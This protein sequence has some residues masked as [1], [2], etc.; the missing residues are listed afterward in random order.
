LILAL[1]ILVVLVLVNFASISSQSYEFRWWDT[2]WHY[3]VGLEVNSTGYNRTNWTIEYDINFTYLL[4]NMSVYGAL[5]E[6]STRVVEYNTTGSILWEVPSQFDRADNYNESS[7]AAGT[8]VFMMNGTTAADQKR[9]FFVYFDTTEH[10]SKNKPSYTT[11]LF[12][13]YTGNVSEFNINN[14]YFRWWVDTERGEN[15]SG[16]YYVQD[17]AYENDILK[18][19]PAD[20][21]TVEYSE[22]SNAT[23]KFGFDFRNNATFKYAGPSRIV[24]EQ[25]GYETL[26]DQPDNKTNEGYMIKRYTFY[27]YSDWMK[28][29]QIFVNNAS[30]NITRN[31]TAAGALAI[32]VNYSFSIPGVGNEFYPNMSS[33]D[34]PGSYGW[35]AEEGYTWWAGIINLYENGTSNFFATEHSDTGRI[36]VQLNETNISAGSTIRHV[37]VVQ[38]NTNGTMA[39]DRFRNFVNQSIMQLNVTAYTSEAWTVIVDGK[40]YMNSTNEANV[41]NRNET[42]IIRANVTDLY[43]LSDKVNASLD[44]GGAGELNLTLYD[45]GTHGDTQANDNIYANTYNIADSDAIGAWN[46][47]FRVY[48]QSDH[49]LSISWSAFNVTNVYNV[50]VNITNPTGFTDRIVNT[51]VYVSNYRRDLWI[52]NA[53]L[54]CT[55]ESTQIPQ[56]NISDNGDGTY[57]VWFKAPSY[58]GLF[59]LNCNAT[60]NNNTGSGTGEFSCNTYTTNMSIS[61]S[62]DNF[63]AGNVTSYSNQTFNITVF[64]ENTANGTAYDMNITLNFPTTNITANTTFASCGDVLITKNCTRTFQI[65]M[66]NATPQGNYSVNISATW[67]NWV[68]FPPGQNSTLLNVTILANP[69]L[70]VSKNYILGIIAPGK[71]P[72]NIDNFTVS[73]LGNEPLQNVTF[74]LQGFS[75]NF[76]FQFVPVNFSFI[77][78][79]VAENVEIMVNSTD[80]TSPGEY[81]GTINVTSANNGFKTINI[82]VAVSG[83]NMTIESDKYNFTAENVTWYQNQSFPILVNTTNI[84][85]SSAYNVTIRLNFSSTNITTN[86]TSRYCGNVPKSGVCNASFLIIILSQ[87]H[88][89]NYTANVSVEWENPEGSTSVNVTTI[90]ITVLSHINLSIPQDSFST[91]VSHGTEKEIGV[92]I[93]NS[94]GNDPVENI[95]FSVYNFSSNFAFEFVPPNI[96]SLGGEYPQGAK[97]NVTVAFG[98][99]PGVYTGKLNVTTSNDGYKEINLT[100]EVPLSRTWTINTTYCEKAESPEEGVACDVLINNTGNAVINYS[101]TPVTN[102]TPSGMFNFTWTNET[103]FTLAS[104]Q[105]HAFSVLYNITNQTIKFYYANYTVNAVQSGSNPDYVILQIVLSPYIKPLISVLVA[106]NQTEQI[107]SVWIYANVTDQGGAGIGYNATESNVTV[108]VLRPDGSNSTIFMTFYGGIPTGG[109]SFWRV[110]YPDNPYAP[111][112]G[113]WG[114]TTSK[115]YYNVSVYAIDNMGKNNTDNTSYFQIYSKLLVG[116]NAS[117]YVYLG[118]FF[119]EININTHDVEGTIL[120][121]TNVNLTLADPNGKN[122]TSYIWMG[123]TFVTDSNGDASGFYFIPQNA[124]LGNYTFTAN[125]THYLAGVNKTVYNTTS[126]TFEVEQSSELA[127]EVE[128]PEYAYISSN[129]PVLV[130]VL[131]NGIPAEPDAINLTIFYRLP[132]AYCPSGEML[133]SVNRPWGYINKTDFAPISPGFYTYQS[134][135][136]VEGTTATG[137]YLA[138]LQ[139]IRHGKAT[140]DVIPFKIARGGPYDVEVIS[141]ESEVV[142]NDY[143]DFELLIENRGDISNQDVWVEYWVSGMNQTWDYGN[144]SINVDAHTN[145]TLLR[146]LFIWSFQ[147]LGMYVLNAKV[148]F[149]QNITPATANRT[150]YV[151][152]GGPPQPPQP[153]GAPAG[154]EGAAGG[155]ALPPKIEI[156]KYPQELGVELD[157]VK[158]PT[159]E[160]KNT[161]GSKLYNVTLRI[162]GIPSPWIQDITP[163]MISELPVGNSSTFTITLKIPQTAEAKEYSGKI[164]AD[165]NI[166]KDEKTFLLT[167]FTTRAQLIQWEI[168]RLKKSLQQ[169]EFDVENAK[170]AGKDTQEVLPYIDQIKEYI[171]LAEDYLQKKMYDES[172]S[173][174]HSGWSALEKAIYLLAQAPFL[175]ILIET[176]FPPWLI[177]ILVIMVVAIVILLFFVRKMK[178]VFDRIFRIQAPGGAPGVVK[179]TVVVERMRERESLEKE[180]MNIRKV[181]NLLERQFKEGLITENAYMSLKARNEEKLAKI[182]QRKAAMK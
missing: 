76:T 133:V 97:V 51:T 153:P 166:T 1:A 138:L 40:F 98:Q 148:T 116:L 101:I 120:P 123:S 89:G 84:G 79:G 100:I 115:G 178:G 132:C 85:N 15:T 110:Q 175:Q 8:V 128:I 113:V 45:D 161:G 173:E 139:V 104:G 146:Q 172:L 83:T 4:N 65:I 162:T 48:N 5:D 28:I 108:T 163:K 75:S 119:N 50:T 141:I 117:R 150:F 25:K 124:V 114:N 3:R 109:T 126:F 129:I 167:V 14:T 34:D 99:A 12:Y 9:Y 90:N 121:G 125:S 135:T 36:G 56:S 33:P 149:D 60:R 81:N 182:E 11:D 32:Y 23:N 66:L 42:V 131:D 122:K 137:D 159:V 165:A 67:N 38:F 127:A 30:Y 18:V 155:A 57:N 27:P 6:N 118:D 2:A 71:A 53:I 16:L 55:F 96:S 152:E 52:T 72:K 31:S 94:T 143:V 147:P 151:V 102:S 140:G 88:S 49:Q 74:D 170:K 73:S 22:F 78:V 180:E 145:R 46:T 176:I 93:L 103:N 62:P 134:E 77:G 59:T 63:T 39:E 70:E 168:E 7:N 105:A 44:L 13:N 111:S 156:I 177:A 171:R 160:V 82:T 54:N 61:S 130:S 164:M 37:A 68:G 58:A 69:I 106:P 80:D 174:V 24:V 47:T 112:Q 20:N 107:E 158:Y 17:V 95:T 179:T 43:N 41:F 26:W 64:A 136:L 92:L 87:T 10:G 154:G 29:E 144:A 181:M 21:K 35:A 91:N 142:R 169:F 19:N 86:A 157:A